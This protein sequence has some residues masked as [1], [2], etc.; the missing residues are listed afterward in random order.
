MEKKNGSIT[1]T[2]LRE[3]EKEK[4]ITDIQA[5]FKK[6]AMEEFGDSDDEVISKKEV[7][8][9]FHAEGAESYHIVR[10]GQIV[11][12][13]V[14]EI[15]P[16]TN[17]NAL[18]LLYVNVN[19]HSKGIGLA[20]WQLI[21]QLHPETEVRETCTPYFEKRNIHFYVNK[22]GFHITEFVNPYH[23]DPKLCEEQESEDNRY[24]MDYFLYFEKRMK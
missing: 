24:G 5:A 9:S 19:E 23:K 15:H 8:Q 13:A 16:D 20:A 22:C 2:S 17:R 7:E 1:L 4:F 12:G 11:G 18:S 14:I 10:D 21:E 3:H 6:A